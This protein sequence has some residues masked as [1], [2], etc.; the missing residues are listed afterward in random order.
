MKFNN[1]WDVLPDKKANNRRRFRLYRQEGVYDQLGIFG[2]M[3]HVQ[4]GRWAWGKS[5]MKETEKWKGDS[6]LDMIAVL[7]SGV[8]VISCVQLVC[9]VLAQSCNPLC[10]P[11]DSSPPGSSV[12]GVFQARML[13][14]IAISSS[15]GSSPTWDQ[16]M[17]PAL[18]GWFLTTE[19]P[20]NSIDLRRGSYKYCSFW[21]EWV[22]EGFCVWRE[23]CGQMRKSRVE[24]RNI[25]RLGTASRESHHELHRKAGGR[26]QRPL[27]PSGLGENQGSSVVVPTGHRNPLLAMPLP[28]KN[29]NNVCN[30]Q[31]TRPVLKIAAS[32]LGSIYVGR[33]AM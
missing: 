8:H 24:Q 11:T 15:R 10:N 12:H 30:L 16:A 23:K 1:K 3:A 22:H 19:P 5:R 7:V 25:I 29:T 4:R 9:V 31:T 17:S 14:G 21:A 13:E 28:K 20:G 27:C 26:V 32:E 6:E 2:E 33:Q 18:A